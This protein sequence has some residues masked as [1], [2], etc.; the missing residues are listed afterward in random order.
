[1][2]F[3]LAVGLLS[4]NEGPKRAGAS[5]HPDLPAH[6]RCSAMSALVEGCRAQ[7]QGGNQLLSLD[8][9]C[10][11]HVLPCSTSRPWCILRLP[12]GTPSQSRWVACG[13]EGWG[14]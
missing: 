10:Q 9:P 5:W 3:V 11:A 8:L 2:V 12:V 1:M 7:E 4:E 14:F 13:R 6:S